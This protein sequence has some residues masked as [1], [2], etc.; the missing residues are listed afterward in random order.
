MK[1]AQ[2]GAIVIVIIIVL[3]VGSGIVGLIV[4]NNK[5]YFKKTVVEVVDETTMKLILETTDLKT[6]ESVRGDYLLYNMNGSLVSEG[7]IEN[8]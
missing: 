2:A 7:T 4:A 6:G 3:L 8:V 1:K 5:G